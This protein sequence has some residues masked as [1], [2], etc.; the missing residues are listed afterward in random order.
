MKK[1]KIRTKKFASDCQLWIRVFNTLFFQKSPLISGS[2]C[3]SFAENDLQRKASKIRIRLSA[4]DPR[5]Q[6]TATR[7]NTL[8]HTATRCSALQ[9]QCTATH[10]STLQ[11]IQTLVTQAWTR[12]FNT[13]ATR[14]EKN[15]THV[16]L[17]HSSGSASSTHCNTLRRTA[18]HRGALQHNAEHTADLQTH[19]ILSHSS[20]S[21]SSTPLLRA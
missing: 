19:A 3:G 20:G 4:L 8:Q 6:H 15:G 18:T 9:L 17:L 14:K 12:A 1:K 2:F 7:C 11:H 13:S 16:R 10:C 5:L 21:A